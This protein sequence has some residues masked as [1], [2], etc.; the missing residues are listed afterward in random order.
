MGV[1]VCVRSSTDFA[2]TAE[3][4]IFCLLKLDITSV[5]DANENGHTTRRYT[6]VFR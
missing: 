4:N 6:L 2:K 1:R 3:K 5:T